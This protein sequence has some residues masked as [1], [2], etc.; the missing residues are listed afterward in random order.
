MEAD[1]GQLVGRTSP[2]LDVVSH[3]GVENDSVKRI[4]DIVPDGVGLQANENDA[5]SSDDEPVSV[6]EA[7]QRALGVLASADVLR[8]GHALAAKEKPAPRRS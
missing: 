4:G 5:A 7:V 3:G 2:V 8:N 6:F 1:D